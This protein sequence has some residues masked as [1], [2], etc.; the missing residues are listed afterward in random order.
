MQAL[1]RMHIFTPP[2]TIEQSNAVG[3]SP[4]GI[5]KTTK[6]VVAT[7]GGAAENDLPKIKS[8]IMK[9]S[10]RK[11]KITM[12]KDEEVIHVPI[13]KREVKIGGATRDNKQITKKETTIAAQK[14]NPVFY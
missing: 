13:A 5:L 2:V 8:S 12:A 7:A 3:T 6:V 11:L 4:E 9:Q 1:R 10:K 14:V